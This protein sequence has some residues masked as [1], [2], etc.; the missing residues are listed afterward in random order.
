LL[1]L[2]PVRFVYLL[3]QSQLFLEMSPPLP[4]ESVL[5]AH[6]H[7]HFEQRHLSGGLNPQQTFFG[8]APVSELLESLQI[9][10]DGYRN[11]RGVHSRRMGVV[12]KGHLFFIVYYLIPIEPNIFLHDLPNFVH[13][14]DF[15]PIALH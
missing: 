5:H 8:G 6:V 10:D 3:E 7:S 1:Q 9:H 2:Q 12:T 4:L 14:F 15:L 11:E 13:F